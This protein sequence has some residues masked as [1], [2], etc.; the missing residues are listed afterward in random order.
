MLEQRIRQRAFEIYS[1]REHDPA[2]TDWLQAESEILEQM[3]GFNRRKT[4]KKPK[5]QETFSD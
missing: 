3:R 5:N 2:L 4:D 1:A